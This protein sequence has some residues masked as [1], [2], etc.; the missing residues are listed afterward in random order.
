MNCQRF[1]LLVSD[2]ARGQMMEADVRGEALAHAD[3]CDNC[4][5]RLHDEE[6][7]TSSLKSL[8]AEMASLNAPAEI[9]FR[10]VDAFRARA[11]V[12]RPHQNSRYWLAAVAAMILIVISVIALRSRTEPPKPIT[13]QQTEQPQVKEEEPLV[14]E[15]QKIKPE[16]EPRTQEIAQKPRRRASRRVAN[17]EVANH[18]NREIATDFMPLGYLNPAT[19]QEGGQIIRVELPRSTLVNFGLPVN[20]DRYNE[21]VKADVLLG[22]DGLARAIRFVQ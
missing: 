21:K 13:V 8:A 12:A 4:A 22:V 3:A 18:V 14:V 6:A 11:V 7:L 20:M 16:P 9:E 5:A 1:D 2:L 15:D 19:L 10:L 17:S